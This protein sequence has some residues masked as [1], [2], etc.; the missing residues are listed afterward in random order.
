MLGRHLVYNKKWRSYAIM[1]T[2]GQISWDIS[3]HAWKEALKK[4]VI[5]S[6]HYNEKDTI[7]VIFSKN[8]RQVSLKSQFKVEN[9]IVN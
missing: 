7:K 2:E 1:F 3:L 4:G 8:R 6:R 9:L 5:I